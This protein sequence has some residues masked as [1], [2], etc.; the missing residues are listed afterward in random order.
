MVPEQN[1]NS[2]ETDLGGF[3]KAEALP[4]EVKAWVRTGTDEIALTSL[5]TQEGESGHDPR[6]APKAVIWQEVQL[7]DLR[8]FTIVINTNAAP[9]S[10]DLGLLE[11]PVAKNG[12]PEPETKISKIQVCTESS[13]HKCSALKTSDQIKISGS[14]LPPDLKEYRFSIVC[15][16]VGLNSVGELDDYGVTWFVHL[17]S[18]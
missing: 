18:P 1:G 9:A 4:S 11:G 15:F 8:N 5:L 6:N 10:I 16:W 17:S 12:F 7:K 2:N 13:A 3:V 14:F